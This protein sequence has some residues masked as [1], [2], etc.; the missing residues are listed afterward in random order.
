MCMHT[1]LIYGIPMTHMESA[2]IMI[3]CTC[4]CMYFIA[5]VVACMFHNFRLAVESLKPSKEIIER[6]QAR[7]EVQS[8]SD[9]PTTQQGTSRVAQRITES[10]RER[11]VKEI[12]MHS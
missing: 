5:Y 6:E 1:Y 3:V 8:L 9:R 7:Y 11:L 10:R 12:K 2:A 4:H